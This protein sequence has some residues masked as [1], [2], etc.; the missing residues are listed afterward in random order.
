MATKQKNKNKRKRYKL[1]D[2]K[3][4]GLV[5]RHKQTNKQK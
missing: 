4:F 1:T 5:L 2:E 3:C